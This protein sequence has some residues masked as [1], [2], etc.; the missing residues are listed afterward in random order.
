MA[1]K[2][3]YPDLPVCEEACSVPLDLK[4]IDDLYELLSE[5]IKKDLQEEYDCKRISGAYYGD[6]FAKLM[7]VVIQ[8]AVA[9]TLT[10]Q[11]KETAMDRCVK[12]ARCALLNAQAEDVSKMRFQRTYETQLRTFGTV[13]A[14]TNSSCIPP[15]ISDSATNGVWE[16][17]TDMTAPTVPPC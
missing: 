10:A 16:E 4:Q 7:A 6:A 17:I 2:I 9:A 12:Q 15:T 5:K 1:D 3:C 11:T 8:H 14:D 13:F